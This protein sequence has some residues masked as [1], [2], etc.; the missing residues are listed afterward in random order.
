VEHIKK[1]PNM[2]KRSALLTLLAGALV[3]EMKLWCA[4]ANNMPTLVSG[5]KAELSDRLAEYGL[6]A[7]QPCI[8]KHAD[9][10]SDFIYLRD[11]QIK[12]CGKVPVKIEKLK[13]LRSELEGD[14]EK[15]RVSKRK[16][17]RMWENLMV[18][19]FATIENFMRGFMLGSGGSFLY[20][21][22]YHNSE[23]Y[24]ASLDKLEEKVKTASIRAFVVG[25][26]A[27]LAAIGA[28]MF[29]P[30]SYREG[31]STIRKIR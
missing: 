23:F 5:T 9:S 18:A 3:F 25:F 20:E 1:F 7:S 31:F 14:V 4:S 22:L 24:T 2:A 27:A 17:S 30:T 26:A 10:L 11:W 16:S 6:L 8:L 12:R 28:A 21:V 29:I 13:V 15:E 19:C